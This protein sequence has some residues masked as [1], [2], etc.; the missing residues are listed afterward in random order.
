MDRLLRRARHEKPRDLALARGADDGP[1]AIAQ[2]DNAKFRSV[3]TGRVSRAGHAGEQGRRSRGA[4]DRAPGH[5][6]GSTT[7][8]VPSRNFLVFGYRVERGTASDG[9]MSGGNL[10]PAPTLQVFPGET[11]IVHLDNG[12]SGLTIRDYFSPQYTPKGEDGSDLSRADDVIAAEPS[13]P[14]PSRQSEGKFRQCPAAHP[15]TAWRIPT[16][17]TFRR[18]AAG[19]LLVSQPSARA[20]RGAGLYRARRPACD[21][22]H[23][24]QPAAR[25]ANRIPIRNMVLQYNFVFDRDGGLAQLNNSELAAIVSSIKPPQGDELANG[26][27]RPAARAGQFQPV[28]AGREI[29][30]R[31]VCGAA[32]DPQRP[33]TDAVHPEQSA[34]LHRA[35][36]GKAATCR[37]IR[38]SRTTQ[39]DVQFTVNGQFQP[40]IK[41]KAG[42]TEIWVLANVSD[43]AY[44]NVQLT[45]TA[46]GTASEDRHRRPGRKSLSRRPLSGDRERHPAS[47]SAGEPVRHRGD[48]AC[49]R[50]ACSRDAA[51]RRRRQ[52]D[53]RARR[54]LH[55]QRHRQSARPCSAA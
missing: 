11:L 33:R 2:A 9:E 47:D 7:V 1:T 18:T 39:R 20:H 32:L 29:L 42:Q 36:D 14:R 44:M 8:A 43:F 31:L 40:M 53:H 5:R 22:T 52:D 4:A 28:E 38:R 30:H 50:R 48:D 13:R 45:E 41:S 21:R 25:D 15:P 27:Y 10:Y 55:Q 46:T 35:H 26:T 3:G 17:T 16:P 51:A 12:L 49:E 23:R 34:A 37:P 24:R 6:P 54:A 19:R